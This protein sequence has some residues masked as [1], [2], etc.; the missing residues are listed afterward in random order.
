MKHLPEQNKEPE[1]MQL[2][3]PNMKK[4]NELFHPAHDISNT[5]IETCE[6]AENKSRLEKQASHHQ[7]SKNIKL[8]SIRKQ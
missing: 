5:D 3:S 8:L 2:L 6:L 7:E 1:D 4:E